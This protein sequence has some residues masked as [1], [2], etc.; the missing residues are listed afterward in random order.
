MSSS[1]V[2][3]DCKRKLKVPETMRDKAFRCPACKAVISPLSKSR[4]TASDPESDEPDAPSPSRAMKTASSSRS[5]SV[6]SRIRPPRDEEP[7]DDLEVVDEEPIRAKSSR[8]RRPTR[9]KSSTGLIVGLMMGGAALLIV[10]A[11][12]GGL[13]WIL[14]RIKTIPESE[15]QVFAPPNSGCTVLMPGTPE[16]KTLNILGIT[17]TQYEVNRKKEDAYFGVAT[18]DVPPQ[19]L[20]PNLLE[21]VAK[22]ARWR[23][24]PSTRQRSDERNVYFLEELAGSRIPGQAAARNV[25]R[26]GVSR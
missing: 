9:K 10:L 22:G 17:M 11:L 24:G 20:R 12:G 25:Y 2:C 16:S 21:D 18:F 7:V 26:T 13:V 19:S 14:L 4:S 6:P 23:A 15:W 5:A 3:P 1:V 8:K